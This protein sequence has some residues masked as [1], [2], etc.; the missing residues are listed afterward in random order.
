VC[1]MLN[2]CGD[3]VLHAAVHRHASHAYST[4]LFTE[5]NAA[6]MQSKPAAAASLHCLSTPT[7]PCGQS[8]PCPQPQRRTHYC[9][10]AEP[11]RSA[12]RGSPAASMPTTTNTTNTDEAPA[13]DADAAAATGGHRHLLQGPVPCR[14]NKAFPY[15]GLRPPQSWDWRSAGV[16]TPVRDQLGVRAVQQSAAAAAVSE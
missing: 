6:V 13:A 3:K 16:I 2:V 10:P 4:V 12:R 7:K 15:A 9:V 11:S 5:R 1:R 14:A 8:S